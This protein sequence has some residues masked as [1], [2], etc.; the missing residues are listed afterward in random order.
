MVRANSGRY[1]NRV[2]D[3]SVLKSGHPFDETQ[4]LVL[5]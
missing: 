3:T 1:E 4:D 5:A 2:N